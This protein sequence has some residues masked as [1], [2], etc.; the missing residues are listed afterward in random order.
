MATRVGGPRPAAAANR[1]AAMQA[2][3]LPALPSQFLR[4]LSSQIDPHE[5]ILFRDGEVRQLI[6]ILEKR[7]ENCPVLIGEAGVGKT[8]I[9]EEMIRRV[10]SGALV[11]KDAI[12]RVRFDESTRIVGLDLNGLQSLRTN[13]QLLTEELDGIIEFI[14]TEEKEG[15]KIFLWLDEIHLLPG[16]FSRLD[17]ML[18]APTG[19]GTVQIMGATTTAEY[20]RTFERDPALTRRFPPIMVDPLDRTQSTE[21][22]R[23]VAAYYERTH[24]VKLVDAR[25]VAPIVRL[26][27]RFL[28]D[29]VLPGS[30]ISLLDHSLSAVAKRAESMS[31]TLFGKKKILLSA[32]ERLLA[33]DDSAQTER[34]IDALV[35][36]VVSLTDTLKEEVFQASSVATV[37]DVN[38]AVSSITGRD[39]EAIRSA[40]SRRSLRGLAGD[41]KEHVIGQDEAIDAICRHIIRARTGMKEEKKPVCV[42][43]L[44][45]PT[46]VGKTEIARQLARRLYGDEGAMVRRDMSEYQER[47]TVSAFLGSPPGYVG[48]DEGGGLVNAARTTP[49]AVM[50]LDEIEKAHPDVHKMF[51]G[52]FEDGVATSRTGQIG[53][54]DGMAILMTSNLTEDQLG[55]AFRPEF[56]NRI[57]AVVDCNSL[58]PEEMVPITNLRLMEV[59][60]R[61]EDQGRLFE[62]TD[63]ATAKL[64]EMG[65]S[66]TFGARPLKRA[67]G[68]VVEDSIALHILEIDFDKLGPH[69][70]VKFILDVE[71]DALV[72]RHEVIEVEEAPR[73]NLS[74]HTVEL[75]KNLEE[76][77]GTNP[78]DE[79]IPIEELDELLGIDALPE[80]FAQEVRGPVTYEFHHMNPIMEPPEL[81]E[82]KASLA[83]YL[84][85]FGVPQ[86]SIEAT[87]HWL[88]TYTMKAV[89]ANL[90]SFLKREF[91]HTLD[92]VMRDPDIIKGGRARLRQIIMQANGRVV[93]VQH[94]Q[95]SDEQLVV[96]VSNEA[97]MSVQEKL[98]MQALLE[99]EA[100]SQAAA[101]RVY[102]DK[103][104]EGVEMDLDLLPA[105][106]AVQQA[107][108]RMFFERIEGQTGYI[109][110]VPASRVR[111]EDNSVTVFDNNFEEGLGL[112]EMQEALEAQVPAF[113]HHPERRDWIFDWLRTFAQR[114]KQINVTATFPHQ[115]EG[116]PIAWEETR[117]KAVE[118]SWTIDN[119]LLSVRVSAQ[120]ALPETL[121]YL[122]E[123]PASPEDLV[124][125]YEAGDEH[126]SLTDLM[127]L[128]SMAQNR[129]PFS[130]E[131]TDSQTVFS[132]SCRIA[133]KIGDAQRLQGL[134][135]KIQIDIPS[136]ELGEA[137]QILCGEQNPEGADA[138]RTETV[139]QILRN[140]PRD[141][142]YR[143]AGGRKVLL[144]ALLEIQIPASEA[145]A[146]R[147]M[148]RRYR[149]TY[150]TEVDQILEKLDENLI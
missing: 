1:P 96:F 61:V 18:K 109:L 53:R 110:K 75:F 64:A 149:T 137:C 37:E 10:R 83:R 57:D 71:E 8:A 27:H 135:G 126:V 59:R 94:G 147:T 105:T 67:I 23:G 24:G 101:H 38:R 84:G 47:H 148:V 21:L 19:R 66:E 30:A 43:L 35:G 54:F 81:P 39:L 72:V 2:A 150:Q 68:R 127:L 89:Q 143:G 123:V 119:G 17:Q 58:S 144:E 118:T 15:R 86:E 108:L 41:L 129:M 104:A 132:M 69:Q 45:G 11:V 60:A 51:L 124:A 12:G 120:G 115:E 90:N 76:R 99:V 32:L 4:D 28:G 87:L 97:R 93:T 42:V 121:K 7:R 77:Y 78:V 95:E 92:E 46:G 116:T 63:A 125:Y 25:L 145:E 100:D 88:G 13:P 139:Q 5:R 107:G 79:R 20:R 33:G 82:V 74:T 55:L 141:I 34:E 136:A 122:S 31:S 70:K 91:G 36:E 29:R 3:N 138:L 49:E 85:R 112:A 98:G 113:V 117:H 102:Q 142:D 40:A 52:I 131:T 14:E 44:L 22:L 128:H 146:V 6:T 130:V 65:H 9:A 50:L 80:V 106:V 133:S 56:L 103:L 114:A 73:P 111:I 26:A 16:E 48:S 62:W 140:L 134:L